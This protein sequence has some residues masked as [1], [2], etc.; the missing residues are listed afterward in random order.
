M[1][2]KKQAKLDVRVTGGGSIYQVWPLTQAAKDWLKEH[3]TG[4][5]SWLGPA[6]CVEWHYIDDL[7]V[8]MSGD[9]LTVSTRNA[10]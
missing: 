5:Q 6:L 4:E 10:A 3:M 1:A 9:G 2:K 7:L 8:G